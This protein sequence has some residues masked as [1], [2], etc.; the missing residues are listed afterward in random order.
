MYLFIVS[1][2]FLFIIFDAGGDRA[3]GVCGGPPPAGGQCVCQRH[4]GPLPS[5]SRIC[6]RSYGGPR[7]SA[8]GHHHHFTCSNTPH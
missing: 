1:N 3:G 4:P 7:R 5:T 8:A 2:A 6:L